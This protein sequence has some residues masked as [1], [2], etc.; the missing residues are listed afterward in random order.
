MCEWK[1]FVSL[2]L[3]HKILLSLM[4]L[5]SIFFSLSRMENFH[6]SKASDCESI[7]CVAGVI[8]AEEKIEMENKQS[9]DTL[10]F[11]QFPRHEQGSSI[12]IAARSKVT[13][14]RFYSH[15]S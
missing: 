11:V 14:K 9:V 8:V 15:Q 4:H 2:A 10:S 7:K 3:H 6:S 5:I 13:Q 1:I 12:P